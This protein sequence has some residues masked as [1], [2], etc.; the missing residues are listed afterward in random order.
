MR[1]MNSKTV[2]IEDIEPSY[3]EIKDECLAIKTYYGKDIEIRAYRFTFLSEKITAIQEIPQLKSSSFLSSAILINFT[4]PNGKWNSYLFN[5]IVS[6]PKVAN[7]AKFGAI[8]LLNYYLHIYKTFR[9]KVSISGH[10]TYE[11][12]IIG[13]FF[14]QQNRITSVCAHASL[15]MTINNMHFK[16]MGLQDPGIISAEHIN[17]IIGVDHDNIKFGPNKQGLTKEEIQDVLKNFGLSITWMNFFENPNVEYNEYIYNYVESK[18]PVLLAFTTHGTALHVVPVLGHTLNSDMWKPE[19][20]SAYSI[21][22]SRLNYK[23]TAAWVDHFIIHDDNFGMYSCLPIDALKRVTLAKYDPTFR[24]CFAVVVLPSGVTTPSWEAE[25]ASI[26][27]VKDLL[28][29]LRQRGIML[30]DWSYK[31]ISSDEIQPPRPIVAR[32]FLANKEDYAKSLAQADSEGKKFSK[33]DKEKLIKDLPYRFWLSEITLPDL[34]TANKTKIID[35]FYGSDYSD[36]TNYEDIFQRW[37]QIRFPYL[38]LKR[39]I[40]GEA[41]VFSMSVKSHYPILR[42]GTKTD[43]LEW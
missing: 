21:Q 4:D 2:G 3:S 1:K 7:Y 17:K 35:F 43:V 30:D 33:S 5:A 34:Y 42:F 41:C 20:E 38:L 37:I 25:W 14:C 8:P 32:T 15:C 24:A 6:I 18:C 10:N 31:I 16:K 22:G 13:T 11:F 39:R 40:A 12:N 29:R 23:S 36:L 26:V 19:A 28:Q 9:C 27:V